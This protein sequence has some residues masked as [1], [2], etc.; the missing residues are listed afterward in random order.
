MIKTFYKQALLNIKKEEHKISLDTSHSIEKSI[1]MAAYLR[2]LLSEMK[3]HVSNN[4]F[5][6]DDEEIDFFKTIKP[7]LL[8]KLIYYNKV[9]KIETCC[10]VPGGKMYF[11]YF[12][13]EIQELKQ[14]F[15]EHI[16]NSDFYRYYRSGRTDMDHM[17]FQRGKINLQLGLNSFAFEMDTNFSTYYDFKVAKI[18]SNELLYNYLLSKTTQEETDSLLLAENNITSK[19]FYWSG[20]KTAL[21]E[22]IYALHASGAISNGKAGISQISRILQNI[23]NIQLGDIHHTFHRMKDRS[24]NRTAFLSQLKTSLE[25]YMDKNL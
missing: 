12:S 5:S 7:Q 14:E 17:F 24:G 1:H 13:N 16:Y 20:S 4:A 6:S 9:F 8:G 2:D 11:K 3:K 22:L 25:E 15:K 23:F 21:I 10:P 19:D 18:I